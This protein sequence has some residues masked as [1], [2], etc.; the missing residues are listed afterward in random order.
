VHVENRTLHI[1]V[2]DADINHRVSISIFAQ[3]RSLR[4]VKPL[5]PDNLD[6]AEDDLGWITA[7]LTEQHCSLFD[8]VRNQNQEVLALLHALQTCRAELADLRKNPIAA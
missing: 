4:M 8:E 5:P 6:V 3:Q 7:Q 1:F 2:R